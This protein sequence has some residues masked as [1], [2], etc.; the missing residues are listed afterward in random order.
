[1]IVC[2]D[3]GNGM[4]S[5]NGPIYRAFLQLYH[6]CFNIGISKAAENGEA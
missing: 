2:E 5:R 6:R 3:T 1:M 4:E